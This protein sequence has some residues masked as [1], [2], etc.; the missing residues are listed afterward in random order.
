MHTSSFSVRAF[1]FR[2]VVALVLG[3]VI[4][5][6]FIRTGNWYEEQSVQSVRKV[7]IPKSSLV[8][9]KQDADRGQPANFLIV[10]NDSR[11]FVK[12]DPGA[13]SHFGSA[14]TQTGTRSDSIM[15][16]HID[17]RSKIAT[18]LS[19][20]RDT[21]VS[22]PGCQN[23]DKINAT[24]NSDWTTCTGR[25]GGPAMLIDTIG[26][27][28]GVSINHYM[29]VD[30]VGFQN[31][32]DVIGHVSLYFPTPARDTYS[33]LFVETGG[34]KKLNGGEALAYARSRRYEWLSYTTGRWNDDPRADLGRIAR[35]QYFIR[36][37]LQQ[38]LDSGARDLFKAKRMIDKIVPKLQVDAEFNKN[39]L[40][41]LARSFRSLDARSVK[42][43]TVPTYGAI[44]GGQDVQLLQEPAADRIFAAVRGFSTPLSVPYIDPKRV[45]VDVRNAGAA[46]GAAGQALTALTSAGFQ[47]GATG[48]APAIARTKVRVTKANRVAGLVVITYLGGIGDLEVVPGTGS[49]T[50]ELVLGRDFSHVVVP[51]QSATT[52]TTT[53]AS[54]TTTTVPPVTTTT[55]PPNPGEPLAGA[56]YVGKQ[57]VGCK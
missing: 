14:S 9:T 57:I 53:V 43:L 15:I 3:G 18:L 25:R 26:S 52:T 33:G 24:F 31:I 29:E 23:R 13:A 55:I 35:Q 50:V 5:G 56:K 20:P 41:R 7:D 12:N 49:A 30:F 8:D 48:S 1:A 42:M 39:D 45:K 16:A 38:A 44:K 32:V 54:P 6:A 22:I 37:L 46:A 34:C 40:N 51:K 17:P 4:V 21:Y 27:N 28:F 19:I 2:F 47:P 11:D 10:G 36:T